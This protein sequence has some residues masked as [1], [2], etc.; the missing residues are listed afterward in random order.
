MVAVKIGPDLRLAVVGSPSYFAEH[1]VPLSPHE[2][3]EHRCINI[4]QST[5]GG[6]YVWEFEKDGREVN[7]RVEGPL[8]LNDSRMIYKAAEQGL[9]LACVMED[10]VGDQIASCKL[11]RVLQDWCPPFAGYHLYYPD[12]R[13]ITPAFGLLMAALR[14]NG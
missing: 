11:V 8:I 13:Q 7:V 10:L 5:K 2:L 6:F 4:R 14:Y 3:T 9:G 12:R 1:R